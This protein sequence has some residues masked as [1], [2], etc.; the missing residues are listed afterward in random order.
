[1]WP[2]SRTIIHHD[3]AVEVDPRRLHGQLN[4]GWTRMVRRLSPAPTSGGPG[5]LAIVRLQGERRGHRKL[6]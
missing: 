2:L 4:A 3:P 6:P 5:W 1:M